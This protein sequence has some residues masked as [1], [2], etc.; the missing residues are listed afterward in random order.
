MQ[1]YALL[2]QLYFHRAAIGDDVNIIVKAKTSGSDTRKVRLSV[3]VRAVN[4]IGVSKSSVKKFSET[5]EIKPG[6]MY[7]ITIAL[8]MQCHVSLLATQ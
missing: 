5:V 3:N 2:Y 7:I 4:Y 6:T 8:Y 1:P